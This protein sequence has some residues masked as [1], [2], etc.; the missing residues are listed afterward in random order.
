M[1]MYF[2]DILFLHNF[3]WSSKTL[4]TISPYITKTKKEFIEESFVNKY[5]LNQSSRVYRFI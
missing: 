5:Y 2:D 3:L 1:Y 4:S